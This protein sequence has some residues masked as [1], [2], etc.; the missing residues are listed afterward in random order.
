METARCEDDQLV[1]DGV[2]KS[3]FFID[4]AGPIATEL[5]FQW[6]GF[7]KATE[8]MTQNI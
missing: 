7:P 8:R 6:F 1:F 3:M 4:S 5:M 2:H